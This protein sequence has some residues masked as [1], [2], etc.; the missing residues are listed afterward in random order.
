M[1]ARRAALCVWFLC[2]ATANGQAILNAHPG[3]PNLSGNWIDALAFDLEALRGSVTITEL[4]T[5]S[6]ADAGQTFTFELFIR[7]GTALGGT[8]TTGPTASPEGWTSLGSVQGVQGPQGGGISLPVDIPDFTVSPGTVRGVAL[9]FNHD[10][11]PRFYYNS[12]VPYFVYQDPGV[13]ITT[14]DLRT[15]PFEAGPNTR[16][17][18]TAALV[19]SIT[20]VIPSVCYPNC[21]GSAQP[22]ILNVSDFVCFQSAFAAGAPYANCDQSTGNP[23]LNVLDFVCFIQQFAAGCP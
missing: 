22:P 17:L 18:R 13:K 23:A 10:W 5:A 3:P 12:T 4:Q 2:A 14:G 15:F 9:Y 16:L 20:Y 1:P 11:G 6:T 21:D 19:G 8:N 7:D